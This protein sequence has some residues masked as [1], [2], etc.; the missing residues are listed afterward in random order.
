[1]LYIQ[2]QEGQQPLEID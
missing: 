2:D 1:V